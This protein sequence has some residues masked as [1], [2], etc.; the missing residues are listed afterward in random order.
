VKRITNIFLLLLLGIAPLY[1]LRPASAAASATIS[2][3]P[4]SSTVKNG[5]TFTVN[6]YENS[7]TEPVNAVEADLSYPTSLL[8]FSS[9]SSS[10][11]CPINAQ[12]TGG[13]GSVKIARGCGNPPNGITGNQLVASVRFTAKANSGIATVS[14]VSGTK[15]IS[16]NTNQAIPITSM[17]GGKYTMRTNVAPSPPPP[18]PS[19]T[20]HPSPPPPS[21]SPT[22]THSPSPSPTPTHS[23]S[24]SPS[25]ITPP[26]PP[27][28]DGPQLE[29]ISVSDIGKNTATITWTTSKPATSEINY[30][31][32]ANY[33]LAGGN[34]KMTT[35]HKVVLSSELIVAGTTYHFSVKSVDND[36]NVSTSADQTFRTK[37]VDVEVTVIDQSKKVISGA[38]VKLGDISGKT[39]DNGRVLLKDMPVGK[40]TGTVTYKGKEQNVSADIDPSNDSGT[41]QS[42]TLNIKTS[43][44]PIVLIAGI[45]ILLMVTVAV[46]WLL[47][48]RR[49]GGDDEYYDDNT[50]FGSAPPAQGGGGGGVPTIYGSA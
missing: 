28:S 16:A 6:I 39:G 12:S 7:G 35:S 25:R 43:S 45:P 13:S 36:G 14:F 32:T 18:S 46:I 48:K 24:P 15:V 29:G 10:S 5:T 1:T 49:G 41:P 9:I 30:G 22:P 34:G 17:N 40:L 33:D 31:I 26:P 8:N 4:S 2:L 20:P 21:P 50:T 3:S 38:T 27:S 19:P 23:P 37:G 47:L 11:A 42:V 44:T